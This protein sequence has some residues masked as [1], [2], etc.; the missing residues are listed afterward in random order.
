LELP[1]PETYDLSYIKDVLK[2]LTD[3]GAQKAVLTGV[4]FSADEMGAMA[5]DRDEDTYFYYSRSRIPRNFHG[6]GDVFASTLTGC[7]TQGMALSDAMKLA[8]DFTVLSMQKTMEDPNGVW[9]GV[10]FE[11][12]LPLLLEKFK[13]TNKKTT[14]TLQA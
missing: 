13:T 9:Y 14:V 4:S 7:L 10:N 6:T 3:L 1:Y 2:R 5:Y 8:V 11:Q 12:A